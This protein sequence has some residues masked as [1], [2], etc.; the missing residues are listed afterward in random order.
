VPNDPILAQASQ[1]LGQVMGREY[2]DA[3]RVAL[4]KE[5]GVER[6]PSAVAAVRKRLLGDNSEN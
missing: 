6:N 3:L 1:S 5:V 4:R 2:G